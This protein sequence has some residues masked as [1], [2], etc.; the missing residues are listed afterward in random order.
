MTF[1]A[2]GSQGPPRLFINHLIH[3]I[4]KRAPHPS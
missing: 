3:S 1:T 4:M 2:G